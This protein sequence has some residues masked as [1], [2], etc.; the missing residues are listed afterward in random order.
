MKRFLRYELDRYLIGRAKERTK[1][2]PLVLVENQPYIHYQKGSLVMYAL[3]DYIGEANLNQALSDFLERVAF[4]EPPYTTSLQLL[5]HIR[6][7]TP[8]DYQYVLKDMFET[9]TLFDNRTVSAS[10]AETGTGEYEVHL[11][12]ASK[13]FRAN[14]LGVEKEIAVNDLIDIGVLDKDGNFLYLKKH[15]IQGSEF[16][17][18]VSVPQIPAKAGIDPL[19]KLIDRKPGDNVIGV[20]G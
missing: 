2:M 10:F 16:D 6:K 12:V 4:Q 15:R 3:Q 19:N 17:I 14:E 8:A 18:V 9:I 1:E 5:E 11:Q 20:D 13:K 7:V